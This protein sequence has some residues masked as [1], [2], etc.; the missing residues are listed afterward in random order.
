MGRFPKPCLTCGALT[1]GL[2]YCETHQAE[3]DQLNAVRLQ[4]YKK[5]RPTLYD[6]SYRRRAKAVRESAIYCHLCNEPARYNDPFQADHIIA[7]DKDSPLAA[8]HR[9]CNLKRGNK[10]LEGTH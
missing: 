9:S 1:S 2:S 6:S 4:E 3:K 10:P 8:A 7:G 5:T